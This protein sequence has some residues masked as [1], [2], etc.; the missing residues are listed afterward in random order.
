MECVK[1]IQVLYILWFREDSQDPGEHFQGDS[2]VGFFRPV[3]SIL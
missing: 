1:T 2:Q 3:V